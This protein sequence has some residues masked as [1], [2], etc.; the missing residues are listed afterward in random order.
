MSGLLDLESS[1]DMSEMG[2]TKIGSGARLIARHAM[3]R[4]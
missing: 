1:K 2:E 4:T 3:V